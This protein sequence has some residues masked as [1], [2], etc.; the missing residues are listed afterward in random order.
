[1]DFDELLSLLFPPKLLSSSSC[2][3]ALYPFFPTP[4]RMHGHGEGLTASKKAKIVPVSIEGFPAR[5]PSQ[6]GALYIFKEPNSP[7]K[8]FA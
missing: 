6:S 7:C 3:P 1:M 4:E 8:H 5:G 2:L